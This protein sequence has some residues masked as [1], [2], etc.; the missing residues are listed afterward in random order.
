GSLEFHT[1]NSRLPDLREPDVAVFDLDPGEQASFGDVRR[2]ALKLHAVHQ[3]LGLRSYAKTSGRTGM[4]VYVPLAPGHSFGQVRSWVRV[5]ADRLA[6][7]DP[8]L[9]AVAHGRTHQGRQVTIDHAQNSIGRNTAAPYTVRAVPGAPVSAPVTW[10]EVEA[11]R[12]HPADLTLRTMR[13]RIANVGDL[14]APVLL[15]GQH[16]PG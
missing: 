8:D 14:F 5:L 13:A 11:G 2:T 15:G 10:D 3:D 1:W 7:A 4:H 12:L 9:I 16:L 6:A